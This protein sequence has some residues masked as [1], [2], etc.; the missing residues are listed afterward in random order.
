MYRALLHNLFQEL[1]SFETLSRLLD[2]G[3]HFTRFGESS[4]FCLRENHL[5]AEFNL[6]NSAASFN[7][8]CLYA[9][10]SVEFLRHTGGPGLII[11]HSAIGNLTPVHVSPNLPEPGFFPAKARLL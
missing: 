9:Q 2:E 4:E 8:L 3:R 11:S 6:E 7:K 10:A 5:P 1:P